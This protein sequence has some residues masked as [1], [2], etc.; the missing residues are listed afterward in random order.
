MANHKDI[1]KDLYT[2]RSWKSDTVL[3]ILS[4][5]S[6]VE[7]KWKHEQNLAAQLFGLIQYALPDTQSDEYATSIKNSILVNLVEPSMALAQ[8]VWVMMLPLVLESLQ[9]RHAKY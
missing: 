6:S 8:K 2:K 3:S 9:R 1:F 4:L 5:P 7:H